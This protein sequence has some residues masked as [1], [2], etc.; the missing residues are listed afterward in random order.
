MSEYTGSDLRICVVGSSMR[1]LSGITQ[2]TYRLTNALAKT[3]LPV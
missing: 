3:S 2:Y 1:F